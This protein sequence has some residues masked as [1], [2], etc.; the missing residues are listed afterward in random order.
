MPETDNT[1]QTGG[2]ASAASRRVIY[3]YALTLDGL[4]L[5]LTAPRVV[6]VAQDPNHEIVGHGAAPSVWIEHQPESDASPRLTRIDLQ[7]VP[8][9]IDV[10]PVP[11]QHVGSCV[12]GPFVWHVYMRRELLWAKE[13]LVGT[14]VQP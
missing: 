4:T 1:T 8:T 13:T 6:L 3:K 9:G 5:E 7:F 10:P 14:L 11:W 12:C 2:A